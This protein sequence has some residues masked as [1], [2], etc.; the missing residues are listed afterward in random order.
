[1]FKESDVS[2]LIGKLLKIMSR[3]SSEQ[4]NYPWVQVQWFYK[5]KDIDF[6]VL[7]I[8]DTDQIYIGDN[9]V[10]HIVK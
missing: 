3:S 4:H 10:Q 7:R 1:M 5:K 9:E 6:K 8:S 2:T